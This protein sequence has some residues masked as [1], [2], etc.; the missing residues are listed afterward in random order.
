MRRHIIGI[1]WVEWNSLNSITTFYCCDPVYKQRET[2]GKFVS[3]RVGLMSIHYGRLRLLAGRRRRALELDLDL[4]K[5]PCNPPGRQAY[6]SKISKVK[7]WLTFLSS[8]LVCVKLHLQVKGIVF[9][10]CVFFF[11]Q[12]QRVLV[13]ISYTSELKRSS[14]NSGNFGKFAQASL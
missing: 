5:A 10:G 9:F 4:L 2:D 1:S 8:D 7:P 6:S 11:N 13:S 12:K 14:R 3:H